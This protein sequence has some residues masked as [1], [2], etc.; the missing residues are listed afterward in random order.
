[1]N[2]EK[3]IV[4]ID[5]FWPDYFENFVHHCNDIAEK[6]NWNVRTVMN[7]E[8]KPY[9]RWIPTRTQGSYLRWDEAKYHTAFVLR[10][11]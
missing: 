2:K 11:S 7:Y 9:G 6:N 4:R 3:F 8:L 1:M 5:Q 10:W